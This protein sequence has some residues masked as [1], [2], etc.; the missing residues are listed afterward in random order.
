MVFKPHASVKIFSDPVMKPRVTPAVMIKYI[1]KALLKTDDLSVSDPLVGIIHNFPG[2]KH[3]L[4]VSL[5]IMIFQDDMFFNDMSDFDVSVAEADFTPYPG[6]LA[7]VSQAGRFGDIVQKRAGHDQAR[8]RNRTP[9]GFIMMQSVNKLPGHPGH[10]NR[11]TP[12]IWQH[13][14]LFHEPAAFGNVRNPIHG[15]AIFR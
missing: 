11:M 7:A 1:I 5:R 6:V 10:D 12:D 3:A 15:R 8:I 9:Q 13:P 2:C 4:N 14:I